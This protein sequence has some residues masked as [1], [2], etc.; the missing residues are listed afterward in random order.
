MTLALLNDCSLGLGSFL[1]YSDFSCL[2][3]T[4]VLILDAV[5]NFGNTLPLT[6]LLSPVRYKMVSRQVF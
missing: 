5:L 4:L 1:F 3:V 2:T 6:H